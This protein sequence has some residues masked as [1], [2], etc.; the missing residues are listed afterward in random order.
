MTNT[1]TIEFLN[2]LS[3]KGRLRLREWLIANDYAEFPDRYGYNNGCHEH[4]KQGKL[5]HYVR[6]GYY[7]CYQCVVAE[8]MAVVE[9]G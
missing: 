8:Y 9:H 6:G 2:G 5:Y 7:R 4:P 1:N 3:D